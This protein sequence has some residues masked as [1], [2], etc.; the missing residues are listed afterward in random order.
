MKT[1]ALKIFSAIIILLLCAGSFQLWKAGGDRTEIQDSE[2]TVV[3]ESSITKE[4]D[5]ASVEEESSAPDIYGRVPEQWRDDGIFSEYYSQAYEIVQ[6][7]TLEEKIGQIIIARCPDEEAVET[8]RKY[9]LG[10]YTLYGVHFENNTLDELLELITSCRDCQDIPMFIAVDE[11]GGTVSR[12]SGNEHITDKVFLSPRELYDEGGMELIKKD[13]KEK[14]ELLS[15]LNIDLNL[16]PIC[17]MCND[18]DSFIYDRT[19]GQDAETTSE[20]ISA[21][22]EISQ[23]RGVSVALKHFPGY[24]NNLDTHFELSID[25]RDYEEFNNNDFLPF[26]AGIRSGAHFV[27]MSHNIVNCMDDELPASLSP[28]AHR[29][30]REE[31]GFTGIIVTD[32]LT[33]DAIRKYTDGINPAV[34]AVKSGNDLVMVTYFAEAYDDLLSAAQS[35][36]LETDIIDHAAMRVIACKY[37]KG[38][39]K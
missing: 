8:A 16:A 10:G 24:G 18:A 20:F 32:D 12:I 6:K 30:L 23:G 36:E 28:E 9:H 3:S 17:D 19:L 29:V 15:S 35:G 37:A 22:T 2:Q 31:L 27:L 11:E 25:N 13:A 1:K 33:M 38:L 34:A 4:D 26:E 5:T 21:V 14:A 7:M 39:M